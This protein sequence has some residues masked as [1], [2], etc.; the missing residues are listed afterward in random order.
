MS[1]P[2]ERK[3]WL[4]AAAVLLA[5][6]LVAAVVLLAP[7]EYYTGTNSIRTQ[8]FVGEVPDGQ[9][10]C[11]ADQIVPGGTGRIEM[12]APPRPRPEVGVEIRARDAQRYAGTVP[13][14]AAGGRW[15]AEV[16][17]VER[18]VRAD[19]CVTP[20]GGPLVV[21]GM[22]GLQSDMTANH[23]GTRRF[24]NR[25]GLWFRPPPGEKANLLSRMPDIAERAARF[26]PGWVG[27]WTY[28]VLLLL[29]WPAA[30][31]G[32]V[33]LLARAFDA[34]RTSINTAAAVGLVALAGTFTWSLV[35]PAFDTP[36]EPDHFAYVQVLSETGKRPTF[37]DSTRPAHST[38]E[39]L[40]VD[41][42]RLYSHI[43]GADGK[44]P[45]RAEDEARWRARVE[46]FGGDPAED[47]GGGKTTAA[48]HQAAYYGLAAAPYLALGGDS[49][50]S[51]L[52]AARLASV[53]LGAL[54]A[55]FTV[56]FISEL[57]PRRPGIAVA[58]GL[59]VALFPQLTYISGAVNND[60]AVNAAAAA[61]LWLA[62][63]TLRRGLDVP[64][65]L[66]LGA[67]A[68]ALPLFK[69][70]GFALYPAIAL[71]VAGGLWRHRER[72]LPGLAA[73][74][75]AFLFVRFGWSLTGAKLG[76]VVDPPPGGPVAVVGADTVLEAFRQ[77][78]QV[79]SYF[80]QTFLPRLPFQN[81]LFSQRW[82]AYDI[83]VEEGVAAFGWYAIKF[84]EW[85]Y[86]LIVVAGAG[87]V[88]LAGYALFR[89][90]ALL[91]TRWVEVAVVALAIVGVLGGVAAAFVSGTPRD[92]FLQ[93]EQG[94]YAFTTLAAV[95][96]VAAW[97]IHGAR[98][99]GPVLA[100]ALVA[101]M[102][103]LQLASLLLALS[104]FYS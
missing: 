68:A 70:T 73:L 16:Q 28:A 38:N 84:P 29:V 42:V 4:A 47:D 20:Q 50:W 41:G 34:D 80:W 94:R 81:E 53:L 37:F 66:A 10:L 40:G 99:R 44:P 25:V 27:P 69:Q 26:R 48:T 57:L 64:T 71:A 58:G 3:V 86:K 103:G 32:A 54:V 14:S 8:S 56:L 30:A 19:V 67:T 15:Q 43:A 46:K 18:T 88:G 101:S 77:P 100:G 65:A 60:N 13:A 91:R 78:R 39:T 72:V 63:R 24:E 96:A 97:A 62:A 1:F 89:A 9:T 52:W 95:A 36:D 55:F 17:E 22:L 49:I 74:G 87:I 31:F 7:R 93:P 11:I 82:P 35:N 75:G 33:R 61:T 21:G 102:A 5:G 98:S 104:T 79:L 12:D 23:I 92:P 51:Q 83:Y 59:L 90:R 85:V 45:W 76:T 6:V 2:G